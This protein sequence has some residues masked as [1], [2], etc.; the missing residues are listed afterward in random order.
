MAQAKGAEK[1]RL[2]ERKM[3]AA[4]R[5]SGRFFEEITVVEMSRYTNI[6]A[7]CV[8]F[9]QIIEKTAASPYER[10]P[11]HRTHFQIMFLCSA[12]TT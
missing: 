3:R 2:K 12:E 11:K 9:M 8:N 1:R 5:S 10:K 6:R 7:I 4:V